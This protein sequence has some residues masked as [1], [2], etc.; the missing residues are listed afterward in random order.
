MF[1]YFQSE[2][3]HVFSWLP[4]RHSLFCF[5]SRQ[6]NSVREWKEYFWKFLCVKRHRTK[7]KS[8]NIRSFLTPHK[9]NQANFYVVI[10]HS[11]SFSEWVSAKNKNLHYHWWQSTSCL[12]HIMLLHACMLSESH[13][14]N[15]YFN[16]LSTENT[17]F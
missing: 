7:L 6:K 16:M 5:P 11:Q 10:L 13:Q 2:C 14:S 12:L 1:I 3:Y 15:T 9:Y 17:M 4:F 8:W